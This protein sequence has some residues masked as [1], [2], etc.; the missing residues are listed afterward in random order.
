MSA[1]PCIIYYLVNNFCGRRS[2]PSKRFGG[3][4]I[5]GHHICLNGHPKPCHNMYW[6]ITPRSTARQHCSIVVMHTIK[7][8]LR[9]SSYTREEMCVRTSHRGN[10]ACANRLGRLRGPASKV[11]G[12]TGTADIVVERGE[13]PGAHTTRI[14]AK[15]YLR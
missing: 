1:R 12:R 7:K 13:W 15:Y 4:Q 8:Y 11:S 3:N 5:E 9:A 6:Y 10:T 14:N 2:R